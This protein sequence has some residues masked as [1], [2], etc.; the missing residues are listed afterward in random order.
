MGALGC[1]KKEGSTQ[2]KTQH[3]IIEKAEN[4]T[5]PS[6]RETLPGEDWGGIT[7]GGKTACPGHLG[8]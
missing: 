5:D 8:H 7:L 2:T 3:Q 1:H 6:Y 4:S